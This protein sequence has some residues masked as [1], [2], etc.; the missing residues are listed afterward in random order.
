MPRVFNFSFSEER[1]CPSCKNK[2]SEIFVLAESYPRAVRKLGRVDYLC[3]VCLAKLLAT[4][5]AS[6]R[7]PSRFRNILKKSLRGDL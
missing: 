2:T 4:S 6:I 7:F 5:K 1:T 3:G